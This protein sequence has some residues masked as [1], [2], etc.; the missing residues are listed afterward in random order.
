VDNAEKFGL[1]VKLVFPFISTGSGLWTGYKL[2][3]L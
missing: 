2:G 1:T 3:Q